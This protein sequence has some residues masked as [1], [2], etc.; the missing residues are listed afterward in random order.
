VT[1]ISACRQPTPSLSAIV[2]VPERVATVRR[3]LDALAAQDVRAC[4]EIVFV[5]PATTLELPE[6]VGQFWGWQHV[7]I[8]TLSSTSEARAAGIR[9]ALAP[10]VVLTEDHS[11]ATPG[12]AA[13]LI[14]AHRDDWAAVGPAMLNANPATAVS[15]SNLAIEYGPWLHPVDGGAATH[16]AG[17]NASYKRDVLAAYGD[18]LGAMMEAESVL[19]WDLRRRGHRVA[20]APTA[21]I[22]HENFSRL[23]PALAVKFNLGRMFAGNRATGWPL[24]KRAVYTAGS[25][26]LPFIRTRRA[27]R[28]LRRAGAPRSVPV[29][30]ATLFSLLAANAAG[31]LVGYALGGGRAMQRL[32]RHEFD[33]K[34]FLTPRDQALMYPS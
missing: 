12:W 26:A 2:L 30:A 31:E 4:V 25:P 19:H 9:R 7:A 10:I 28:D 15:W 17:H 3:S 5:S 13:A 32:T 23:P 24:W 33:R 14:E 8:P 22:R 29:L 6:Y 16:I 21:R 18:T 1:D 11:F 27:L 34:V 20:V